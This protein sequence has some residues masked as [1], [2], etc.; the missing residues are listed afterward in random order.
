MFWIDGPSRR[1]S[2]SSFYDFGFHWASL[3][4][5][6]KL[7]LTLS[8][9]VLEL[10]FSVFLFFFLTSLH[11]STSLTEK[12]AIT[13][14]YIYYNEETGASFSGIKSMSGPMPRSHLHVQARDAI[15]AKYVQN[16][17]YNMRCWSQ[18]SHA[19]ITCPLSWMLA[20]A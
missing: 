18:T 19:V 10:F 16:G 6:D 8:V 9:L 20:H 15:L 17:R 2:V 13:I 3:W 14:S 5:S 7:I 11:N 1:F 4:R 12:G